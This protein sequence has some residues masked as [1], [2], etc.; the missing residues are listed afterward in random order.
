MGN[1]GNPGISKLGAVLDERTKQR[2]KRALVLDYATVRQDYS[3]I[4]NTFPVPI[5]KGD[6]TVCRHISGI[7]VQTDDGQ[8]VV[9]LPKIKP[10]DRVLVA[11]VLNDLTVID[12]ITPSSSI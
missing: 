9:T 1:N 3:I 6:Y 7:T 8:N 11:W 10:G 4:T 12:V 2:G 5:P